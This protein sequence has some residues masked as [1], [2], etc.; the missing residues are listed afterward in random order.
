MKTPGYR[1]EKSALKRKNLLT[2]ST[3]KKHFIKQING[4]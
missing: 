2:I 1:L 3:I 4:P